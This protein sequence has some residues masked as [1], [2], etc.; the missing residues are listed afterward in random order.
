MTYNIK[1]KKLKVCRVIRV[2]LDVIVLG[3]SRLMV[4]G[5]GDSQPSGDLC[6][7]GNP[8]SSSPAIA[9]CSGGTGVTRSCSWSSDMILAS[10][11]VTQYVAPSTLMM[12]EGRQHLEPGGAATSRHDAD[13]PAPPSV[14]T[15]TAG[16]ARLSP[17]P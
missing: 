7:A 13:A 17:P 9:G 1:Q 12:R 8:P 3:G 10:T 6:E 11:L 2:Y 15:S 5:D 14:S 4:G 16:S